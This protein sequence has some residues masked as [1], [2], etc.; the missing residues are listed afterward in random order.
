MASSRV[1]WGLLLLLAVSLCVSAAEESQERAKCGNETESKIE[2]CSPEG[3][4]L[5]KEETTNDA[6][7]RWTIAMGAI[8]LFL[9]FLFGFFL[10]HFHVLALPEAG[11]GILIGVFAGL[12]LKAAGSEVP[13]NLAKFDPNFFFI[14]LLPPIIFE[15]GYNMKRQAF[16]RNIGGICLYAFLGTTISCFVVGGM[17]YGFG[18][19]GLCHPLSLLASLIFGALIS[20]TDP[21]T[22]LAVFQQLHAD[23]DLYSLVFGESVLNDAVAIVLYR[24]LIQFKCGFSA[25]SI[26]PALGSCVLIFAGSTVIGLVIAM[27]SALIT[28]HTNMK[29]S[30]DYLF[31]EMCMLSI[32][33]YVSFMVAEGLK[34]SGIVSI[35]FCGIGMA[36]YTYNN[37]STEGQALSRQFF[38]ILAQL[39]ESFVFVY[40]GMAMFLYKQSWS[41]V[42][43]ILF[44]FFSC[45]V[46]RVFN[47]YPNS[48][49]TNL[50]R[51]PGKKPAPISQKFQFVLWFSGLRGAVAFVLAVTQYGKDEFPETPD[52]NHPEISD[53]AAILT[54][55]LFIAVISVFTMGGPIAYFL[56]KFDLREKE[57]SE[58]AAAYTGTTRGLVGRGKSKP[59]SAAGAIYYDRKYIKPFLTFYKFE[60]PPEPTGAEEPATVTEPTEHHVRLNDEGLGASVEPTDEPASTTG[61]G[62]V[63]PSPLTGEKR[64]TSDHV[65]L[66]DDA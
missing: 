64:L 29:A 24:T 63:G 21:V 65:R 26:F 52:P 9:M 66:A 2:P 28:K 57:S 15:S 60:E 38:K 39:A 5:D 7:V 56:N 47:I 31:L 8:C 12:I 58:V 17:V 48:A 34:L 45:L 3:I 19:M 4:A 55:T 22:V 1:A 49:L 10:E 53:S 54:T 30:S 62:G 61:T 36:H 50:F 33:P 11:V 37:L 6:L 18:Q 35:M 44:A 59:M 41:S 51:K 25:L 46:A 14:F 16:F 43:L 32:Y 23:I 42:P 40:L 13:E 27:L 20:A